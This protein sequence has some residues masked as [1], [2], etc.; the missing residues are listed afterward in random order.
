[1]TSA[2]VAVTVGGDTV[3]SL[4]GVIVYPTS[5]DRV[6]LTVAKNTLAIVTSNTVYSTTRT[7]S[8]TVFRNCTVTVGSGAT[9]TF[10]NCWFTKSTRTTASCIFNDCEFGTNDADA[11]AYLGES[12]R[13][14]GPSAWVND[15]GASY[16]EYNDC[17]F[18]H[19]YD[20]LQP[21]AASGLVNHCWISD[22]VIEETPKGLHL[23]GI[24]VLAGEWEIRNSYVSNKLN[25]A[26]TVLTPATSDTSINRG[27]FYKPD[28]AGSGVDTSLLVSGCYV[29]NDPGTDGVDTWNAYY[30][31]SADYPARSTPNVLFVRY[32][33][34]TFA[35]PAQGRGYSDQSSSID[36]VLVNVRYADTRGLVEGSSED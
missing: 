32:E 18:H 26:D 8:N 22:K 24:Q 13:Y 6:G 9:V 25:L 19:S 31:A 16:V 30:T 35:R 10:N 29:E 2:S 17:Y 33:N 4:V 15:Q 21:A 36:T 11:I 5:P 1:M 20:G 34:C 28:L 3:T 27:I 14:V 12:G 23:D 7:V